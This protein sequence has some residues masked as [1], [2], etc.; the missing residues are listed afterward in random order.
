MAFGGAAGVGG[1]SDVDRRVED[2]LHVDGEAGSCVTTNRKLS[3]APC[4][5]NYII[6]FT[7]LIKQDKRQLPLKIIVDNFYFRIWTI[8]SP[9][10]I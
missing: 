5:Y 9:T 7:I 4:K 3:F 10:I 1:R 2:A 8:S 6:D